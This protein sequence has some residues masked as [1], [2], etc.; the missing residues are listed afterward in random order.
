MADLA[1]FIADLRYVEAAPF[2][3]GWLL[4]LVISAVAVVWLAAKV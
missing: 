2:W 3:G 4:A 1:R